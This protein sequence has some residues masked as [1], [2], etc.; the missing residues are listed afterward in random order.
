MIQ[1]HTD[2]IHHQLILELG[3]DRPA[4]DRLLFRFAWE[5]NPHR[6]AL[7][8]QVQSEAYPVTLA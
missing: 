7:R 4:L 1:R 8:D 2:L 5:P 6:S 3:Y